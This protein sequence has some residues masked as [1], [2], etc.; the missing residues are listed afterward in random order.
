MQR[1]LIRFTDR[2]MRWDIFATFY[3]VACEKS[4]RFADKCFHHD[5]KGR[6]TWN[7]HF[8][9]LHT[10]PPGQHHALAVGRRH[11]P[12][13]LATNKEVR[14]ER[15]RPDARLRQLRLR[16][17]GIQPAARRVGQDGPDC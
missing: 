17:E 15:T 7:W 13:P 3:F 2:M 5:K 16:G 11:G 8:L 4:V 14:R 6:K 12:Q 9:C 1:L 10:R